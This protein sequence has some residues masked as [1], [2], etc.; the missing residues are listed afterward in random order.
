MNNPTPN[1]IKEY[2]IAYFD[3]L[4]YQVFFKETP[5]KAL[6]FLNTIHSVI[7]NTINYVQS[8]NDSPLVSQLANMHIQY[9]IFSDNILL[10]IEVGNDVEKEKLRV[11]TFMDIISE[12]Q[13]K[14]ITEYG[15]FLRGG[16]TKGTTSINDDY[17]FGEGLIEAV[18]IEESTSH[19]RI[20]ISDKIINFL[21]QI[22]L[23]TSEE[24][25]KGIS[26]EN[27]IKNGENVSN[28]DMM[29]YQRMVQMGNQ[30]F[31]EHNI[32]SNL[33]YKCDDDVWCLSYLYCL[34]V[35]S[36]IPEQTLEQVLEIMKQVLPT[37]YEKIPKKFP[38][39]DSILDAHRRIVEQKL[40]KYSNYT[41][42]NTNDIKRFEAQEKVLKKYVWSMVYHNHMCDRY[43]KTEHRIR[44]QGN[45]ERRY[46]KLVIHVLDKD[47]NIINT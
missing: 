9:K 42:F 34:D 19:P 35:R 28:D 3:T 17:I 25:D 36:Y 31:L 22:Q 46:M 29:F 2:Y 41:E 4:G 40:V 12:I 20:A 21:L 43:N 38:N 39:I 15:L 10:C 45:C 23:Y 24:A 11:L 32:C 14:F 37:D 44:S 18:K 26:I 33:L 16:F 6:E 8:F 7:T 1:P 5:E 47:E 13:R 30:E 27:R